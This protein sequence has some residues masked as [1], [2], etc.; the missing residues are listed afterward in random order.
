[1]A[2]TVRLPWAADV[3]PPELARRLLTTAAPGDPV[4]A[5]PARRVAGMT[6]AGLRLQPSDPDTTVGRVDVWADPDTGLPVQVEIAAGDGGRPVF[7]S[8]FLDLRQELPSPQ[9][10]APPKSRSVAYATTTSQDLAAL[11]QGF[12]DAIPPPE[13]AGR[14]KTV[15]VPAVAGAAGYGDGFGTFIVLSLPGRLGFQ[16]AQAARDA[17]GIEVEPPAGVGGQLI[18]VRT[19]LVTAIIVRSDAPRPQRRSFLLA[20]LVT[21]QLLRQAATEL[22]SG[23]P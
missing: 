4:T 2:I 15:V 6:A 13:L 20:G 7:V 5:I 3:L 17:G 22:L 9:A 8:R 1:G 23:L 16:W 11:T 19:S 18:E 21:P 10:V 14:P 12:P